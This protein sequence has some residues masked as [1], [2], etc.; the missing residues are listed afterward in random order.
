MS[1]SQFTEAGRK[2]KKATLISNLQSKSA[3]QKCSP[4][5]DSGIRS[6]LKWKERETHPA[7]HT[8]QFLMLP[9]CI[10]CK[11]FESSLRPKLIMLFQRAHFLGLAVL[12]SL[13]KE[14]SRQENRL[15]QKVFLR[16]GYMKTQSIPLGLLIRIPE[17]QGQSIPLKSLEQS[18]EQDSL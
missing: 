8:F 12:L 1:N 11:P 2:K 17:V 7:P 15:C 5:E 10:V 18:H 4:S 14:H 6:F 16:E 9:S 3:Q 13:R